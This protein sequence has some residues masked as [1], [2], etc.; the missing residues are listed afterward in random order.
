M[1]IL[2]TGG[3]GFVGSHFVDALIEEGHEVHV[4]DNVSTGQL[5]NRNSRA[6]TFV[7]DVVDFCNK[8]E[9]QYDRIYHFANNARI[10]RTFEYAEETLLNNYNTTVAVCE[11]MKKTGS[12]FMLF[13][14]SSTT[15]FTDRFNNPYTFSKHQCDDVLELY[16][17]HY[18]LNCSTVKFY[19]VYGS[20]REKDLGEHT[21]VIRK[22]K[23]LVMQ[24][25]PLTVIGTGERRRDFTHI[26]DTVYALMVIN[27]FDTD[28][29]PMLEYHIGT[30]M[31]YKIIDIAKA[32]DHPIVFVPDRVYELQD[33]LCTKAYFGTTIDV[34]EHI[35]QWS[36]ENGAR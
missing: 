30:G 2:V 8:F 24:G 35:K 29:H 13:A 1:L 17:K 12:K 28:D 26:K 4:V 33:T 11:Y 14:S 27:A 23:Q 19:N 20:M 22:F 18:K 21:T 34:I 3:L 15:E 31:S 7:M 36:K 32:F 10:A 16:R 25:K 6:V 9:Y 5:S